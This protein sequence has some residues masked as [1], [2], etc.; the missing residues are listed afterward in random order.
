MSPARDIVLLLTHSADFYTVDR[1]AEELSRRGLRPVRVEDGRQDH[2]VVAEPGPF[3]AGG[4]LDQTQH[5]VVG[6][7]E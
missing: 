5:A 7:G 6:P 2:P 3:L 4:H 1:V